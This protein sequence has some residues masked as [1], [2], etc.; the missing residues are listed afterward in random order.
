MHGFGMKEA[1]DVAGIDAAGRVL[2]TRRLQPGRVTRLAGAAWVLEVSAGEPL[3]PVGS[4]LQ[5][6]A[7]P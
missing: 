4:S 3:P 1:L 7:S 5:I 6:E 2:A